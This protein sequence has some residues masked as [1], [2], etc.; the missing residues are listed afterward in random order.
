MKHKTKMLF[1]VRRSMIFSIVRTLVLWPNGQTNKY[2]FISLGEKQ[3]VFLYFTWQ[4]Q[5]FTG[6][7][8]VFDNTVSDYFS[9]RN[10]E[11]FFTWESQYFTG[12]YVIFENIVSDY[13]VRTICQSPIV[14]SSSK[15]VSCTPRYVQQSN[16]QISVVIYS[17]CIGK[18]KI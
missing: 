10:T 4:S 11:F 15:V 3:F 7:W 16:S 6:I 2:M 12:I 9:G 1:I 5:Y 8:V 18:L 14:S 13:V 17:D